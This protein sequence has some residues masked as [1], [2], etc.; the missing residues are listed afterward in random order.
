MM[1]PAALCCPG[2]LYEFKPVGGPSAHACFPLP[3]R[4][5][6]SEAI[7]HWS[8][9]GK[10]LRLAGRLMHALQYVTN[11]CRTGVVRPFQLQLETKAFAVRVV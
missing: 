3:P 4:V 9:G 2:P 5:E 11:H 6:V 1:A 7:V 10:L 8:Q